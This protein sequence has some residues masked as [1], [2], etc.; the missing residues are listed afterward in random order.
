MQVRLAPPPQV[1][2]QAG[3]RCPGASG[4]ECRCWA[5]ISFLPPAKMGM[6]RAIR[7]FHV[8]RCEFPAG[9][10]FFV[11]TERGFRWFVVRSGF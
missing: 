4:S 1:L 8:L 10:V 9:G 6:P 7:F 11:L 5:R 2:T 3:A